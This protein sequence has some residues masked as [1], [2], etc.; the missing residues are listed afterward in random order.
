MS[1]R[2]AA[3]ATAAG[4]TSKR[5]HP[6]L[7]CAPGRTPPLR[8]ARCHSFTLRSREKDRIKQQQH[9]KKKKT[10]LAFTIFSPTS[11]VADSLIVNLSYYLCVLVCF[12]K[13]DSGL[14]LVSP[15][16]ILFFFFLYILFGKRERVK[17][18]WRR[19]VQVDTGSSQ[20]RTMR[21]TLA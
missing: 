16:F 9:Q 17:D 5:R 20:G 14:S 18:E 15:F 12:G 10:Y 4:S 19:A 1:D 13:R 2:G 6:S 11:P 3:A 7:V 8:W 21:K